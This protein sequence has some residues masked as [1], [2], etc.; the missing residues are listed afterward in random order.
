MELSAGANELIEYH[1]E[2]ENYEIIPQIKAQESKLRV[3]ALQME[4]NL[5][6]FI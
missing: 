5:E 3:E 1:L 6:K 2:N 4:M